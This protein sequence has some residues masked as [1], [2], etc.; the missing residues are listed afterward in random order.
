MKTLIIQFSPSGN[1]LKVSEMIRCELVSRSQQVSLINLAGDQLFFKNEA[2]TRNHLLEIVP[3]HDVLLIGSPVY[4]H[5]LQYHVADLIKALPKPDGKW[6]KFA[7]PFVTYGGISS[8]IA[9]KEAGELLYKSGRIVYAGM[10]IIASHKMTRAF[11]DEE[12]NKEKLLVKELPEINEL[13]N[14]IVQLDGNFIQKSNHKALH[15]NGLATLIKARLIFKEKE[16]HEK[17]YP[18]ISIDIEKCTFCGKCI[19]QCP[20]NHLFKGDRSIV[21]NEESP[22]IHC[23]SCVVGCSKKA[24]SLIGD[25]EKGRAFMGKMIAKNGNRETPASAVYP[26]NSNS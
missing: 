4:A 7:I 1:T 22:C 2:E 17:R 24:I 16:W 11:L 15:Y 18:K 25:L 12:F 6:G 19:T 23:L 20:V 14:R 13:V 5:H 9:L 8:G 3:P 10:K 26:L 21:K